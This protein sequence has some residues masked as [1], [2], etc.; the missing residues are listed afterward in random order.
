ML[1]N[2]FVLHDGRPPSPDGYHCDRVKVF[3]GVGVVDRVCSLG[4]T[5]KG[6]KK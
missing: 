2:G 1:D 5:G 6:E 4:L 3:A